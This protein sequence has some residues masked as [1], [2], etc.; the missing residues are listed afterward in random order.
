MHSD[1]LTE[2]DLK[3]IEDAH[4]RA[5]GQPVWKPKYPRFGYIDYKFVFGLSL[6]ILLVHPR[7]HLWQKLFLFFDKLKN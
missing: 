4:Y 6:G 3:L 5:K 1:A 2:K 7:W